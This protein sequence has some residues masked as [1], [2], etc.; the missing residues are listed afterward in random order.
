MR[1]ALC[2]VLA[3]GGCAEPDE[4][5]PDEPASAEA[6]ADLDAP[7]RTVVI[8]EIAAAGHPD[9]FE[10][11]NASSEPVVLSDFVFS[12]KKDNRA[13][14]ARFPSVTLAPG[15]HYVQTVTKGKQHFKLGRDEELWVFRASDGRLSDGVDWDAGASPPSGSYARVGGW[16]GEF[17]TVP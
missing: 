4:P 1:H 12:D 15:E 2:I 14:A 6:I 7:L 10:V 13:E 9:W 16:R 11:V 3:I 5:E 8:T 17:A